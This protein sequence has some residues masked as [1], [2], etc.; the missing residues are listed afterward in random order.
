MDLRLISCSCCKE[1]T[2][3]CIAENFNLKPSKDERR[4]WNGFRLQEKTKHHE[5]F[6]KKVIRLESTT[7]TSNQSVKTT[8]THGFIQ[9]LDPLLLSLAI[10]L[11]K[12]F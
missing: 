6:E 5:T 2:G 7:S 8:T 10:L 12:G 3:K 11:K 4:P 9:S 1:I